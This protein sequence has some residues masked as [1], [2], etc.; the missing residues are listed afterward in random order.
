MAAVATLLATWVAPAA[1]APRAARARLAH[2]GAAPS[3]IVSPRAG[4][5][6]ANPH[7]QISFLGAPASHLRHIVVTGSKTGVH[8]GRL[9]F[10]STHE[11]AS[12]LPARPFLPGERVTV[13]AKL[14]GYGLPRRIGT[15]F[16]VSS[17]YVLPLPKRRTQLPRTKTNVMRFHSRTDLV[18]ASVSVRTPAADPALGDLFVAPDAGPGQAGAMI[19]APSGQLVWFKPLPWG[20]KA[21]DL[22]VQTYHGAPALT[23]WQG[24]V[25]EYHGQGV[26]VIANTHYEPIAKVHAGNGLFADLHDF[27]ITPQGTAWITA[28]APQRRDLRSVGG[29]E[30]GLIDDGVVQ[31]IDIATGLVM[32]EWHA[33]AHVPIRDTYTHVPKQPGNVLDYF[34]INSVEPLPGERLLISS[35]TTWTVYLVSERTGRVLWRLGGKH[36]SFKLGPGVQFAWQ[37]DAQMRADGTVSLFNND[38]NP[39]KASQSSALDIAVNTATHT[40][41][42]VHRHTYPGRGI[43]SYSQGNVQ[44]LS[45]GDE[46]VGWGHV[47]EVCEFSPDGQLTLDMLLAPPTN[48][49]RAYRYVWSAQ[50]RTAPALAARAIAGGRMRLHASWNGAT[51]VAGWRVLAGAGSATLAALGTYPSSGFETAIVAPTKA[52]Y[53]RVQAL[54]EDGGVLGASALTKVSGH[55]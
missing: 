15:S 32:F 28:Y 42:L 29:R 49:Y 9:A 18:P 6:D 21:F 24:H 50:P 52:R 43:L 14:V 40:A 13:R 2:A 7:T 26:G 4:T 41:T 3:V 16:T 46:L 55:R 47:G 45:N 8:R 22:N 31:E 23:W 48:S 30:D 39:P 33:L 27:R 36:S 11:G 54:S 44:L 53:V 35:R 38:S 10:Y 1:A 51:D 19:L 34:H 37:H 17:P 12:F 5:P 20:V 25:V